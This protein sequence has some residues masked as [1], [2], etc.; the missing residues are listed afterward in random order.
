MATTTIPKYGLQEYANLTRY[1]L[2]LVAILWL[3]GVGFPTTIFLSIQYG[4]LA[5]IGVAACFIGFFAWK[6]EARKN[7]GIALDDRK[8]MRFEEYLKLVV[9]GE[10]IEKKE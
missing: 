3:V 6:N 4:P 1:F 9:G 2:E 8:P 10:E 7:R 5:A